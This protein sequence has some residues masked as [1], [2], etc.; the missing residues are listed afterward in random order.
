MKDEPLNQGNLENEA[1]SPQPA[2]AGKPRRTLSKIFFNPLGL[3]S[4]WRL[5]IF[6]V[7]IYIC[8]QVVLVFS[9]RFARQDR[10]SLTPASMLVREAIFFGVVLAAASIM[11]I[12][13]RRSLADYLLPWQRAFQSR[14]WWGVVWGSLALSA[15]LFTIHID[16][17]FLFGQIVL[18]GSKIPYDAIL[19]ALAFIFVGL[20]EEFTFRGYALY[21]L[22]DGIGF[23]PAAVLLSVLFGAVHL[24][25]P[26]EDWAGALAACLIG[27]FFCFTVRR[28][29]NL[30]FAIGLH[31]AWD[32]AE[33]FLYSVPNSGLVA[34]G[35]LMNSSFQGPR[36]LTGGSVGPEGSL[37]VFAL[38]GILFL[39]FDRIYPRTRFPQP[40][41]GLLTGR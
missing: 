3:R 6:V 18:A 23:W 24:S 12:F 32:Y 34:K 9:G 30:W 15:L 13:E 40:A 11:A 27:F 38:I 5:L 1:G 33:T 14:F 36:W 4:G 2:P 16:H 37:F 41:T 29:G 17:G 21:T 8:S 35:H 10:I 7:I 20:S 28:T 39:V 19:W 25:N 22:T 31:S 26:G